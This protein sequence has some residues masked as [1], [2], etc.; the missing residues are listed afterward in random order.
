MNGEEDQVN[1]RVLQGQRIQ[2]ASAGGGGR[3]AQYV[4]IALMVGGAVIVLVAATLVVCVRSRTARHDDPVEATAAG[5]DFPQVGVVENIY[6][7][8]HT[9]GWHTHPGVH[10]AVVL[11]GTLTVYDAQCQ[12]HDYGAGQP[13]LG[14]RDPHVARNE[15][16]EPVALV[17]TY[18][19]DQKS[20]LDHATTVPAPVGCTAT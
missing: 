17:V 11:S 3:A 14:G 5:A 6:E 7:P 9:S 4:P 10:S 8:G 12:R 19:F 16:A 15:T 13:Y 20:P 1:A 2:S 18:V